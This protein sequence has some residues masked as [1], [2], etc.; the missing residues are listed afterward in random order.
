MSSKRPSTRDAV[1]IL[2]R[3]FFEG[4][5]ERLAELEEARASAAIARQVGDLREKAGLSR[6][7]LARLV[8]ATQEEIRRLEEDDYEGQSL[9]MLHRIAHALGRRVDIRLIPLRRKKK[10]A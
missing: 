4:Q 5:P 1:E 3:R 6:R 10:T 9:E 2:H 8:G 7:Q